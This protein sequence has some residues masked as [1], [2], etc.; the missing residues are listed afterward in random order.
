MSKQARK[1]QAF[2][3]AKDV[4]EKQYGEYWTK[5]VIL[6]ICH[7]VKQ[8]MYAGVPYRTMLQPPPADP[9]LAHTLGMVMK[10]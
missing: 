2:R 7:K 5:R 9:A 4:D 6:E 1:R 8:A 10:V 3:V